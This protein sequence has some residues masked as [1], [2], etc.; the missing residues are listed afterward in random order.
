MNGA[1]KNQLQM[2]NVFSITQ[3]TKPIPLNDLQ[4]MDLVLKIER[5]LAGN[6]SIIAFSIKLS[7]R[8]TPPINTIIQVRDMIRDN[9]VF[10]EDLLGNLL[11]TKIIHFK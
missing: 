3:K 6:E 7:I 1:Y 5:Q 10:M 4:A 8:T 2:A 9:R 11:V